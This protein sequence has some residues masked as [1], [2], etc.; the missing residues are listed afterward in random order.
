MIFRAVDGKGCRI[1]VTTAPDDH[2]LSGPH[3]RMALTGGSRPGSRDL[4]PAVLAPAGELA[5]IDSAVVQESSAVAAAPHQHLETGPDSGV[6]RAGLRCRRLR[7]DLLPR[8]GRW[9]V[10]GA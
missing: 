3:R 5:A 8:I 4:L 9:I 1:E 7:L 10:R 6:E 2:V